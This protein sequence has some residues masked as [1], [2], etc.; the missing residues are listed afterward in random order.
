MQSGGTQGRAAA[1][2]RSGDLERFRS[3]LRI[4]AR[5]HL[6]SI[7]RPKLDPSDLVQQ[8][9]LEAYEAMDG[10][11]AHGHAEQAAWLRTI[12]SRNL[13]DAMRRFLGPKRDVRRERS[14]ERSL[15][16]ST[17]RLLELPGGN[18]ARPS[19]EVA[20]EERVLLLA[21]CLTDMP[22]AEQDVLVLHYLQGLRLDEVAASLRRTPGSVAGLLRRG[23]LRLRDRL[24]R[25][26]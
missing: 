24:A 11:R 19:D 10:L 6:P 23:L 26:G 7:L 16:E 14:L 8:T 3:Y 18:G 20:T 1:A 9:L 17:S 15:E 12:L 25:C 5:I 21:E 4:L 22:E 2:G 13:A